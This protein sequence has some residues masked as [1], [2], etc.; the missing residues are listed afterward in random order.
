MWVLLLGCFDG[1]ITKEVTPPPPP[2]YC[3]PFEQRGG[4][5]PRNLECV[6]SDVEPIV[7]A[8]RLK[9]ELRWQGFGGAFPKRDV[10]TTPLVANLTDDNADGIINEKDSP[11]IV[12]VSYDAPS[13]YDG[14]LVVLDGT[15]GDVHFTREG[16]H[17]TAGLAIADLNDDGQ[18]DI[19]GFSNAR[20]P[21]AIGGDGYY[22]WRA[23]D[24]VNAWNPQLTIADTDGEAGPEVLAG[25]T[26]L[27][28]QNGDFIRAFPPPSDSPN[29]APEVADLDRDGEAEII[30]GNVVFNHD[31]KV[32]WRSDLKNDAG[33]WTAVVNA[34]DD[35]DGE[36]LIIGGGRMVLVEPDGT[37]ITDIETDTL[38]PGPPCIADFDGDGE[39]EAGWSD[40]G[41]L[42]VYE[43]NG[44]PLW[45]IEVAYQGL[46][47]PACSAYDFDANGTYEILYAD[48]ETLMVRSGINGA[49][50]MA[51][52]HENF[53]NW[54]DYPVVADVDNDGSAEIIVAASAEENMSYGGL[55]VYGHPADRWLDAGDAW[56]NH[57]FTSADALPDTTAPSGLPYPWL[58]TNTVRGRPA[59]DSA[60]TDLE[61][62]VIDTCWVGCSGNDLV[63]I[64]VQ[65]HNHGPAWT[66][67]PVRL[68]VYGYRYS[69]FESLADHII[70]PPLMG[71]TSTDTINLSV[72]VSEFLP[73]GLTIIIDDEGEDEALGAQM[74]C[75]ETNN[76]LRYDT[77]PCTEED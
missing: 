21:S 26:L 52:E 50:R 33:L 22:L 43:L 25:T 24:P 64:T 5:I 36:V 51:V 23:D 58:I 15:T 9:Q 27:S 18:P 49:L 55:T 67:R 70:Q 66:T 53:R 75:N 71:G 13:L 62:E 28:G 42:G 61:V 10:S 11:D 1:R 17:P 31:G 77:S 45:Q 57:R 7:D 44:D 47:R 60:G 34:D 4:T 30:I 29:F 35:R 2:P 37:V 63:Q 39:A 32:K 20:K 16:W 19:V 6:Q 59:V 76:R 48:S 69:D 73:N 3:E 12:F 8:W 72:K 14:W 54:W 40:S 65:V 74:E 56:L 46:A 41:L 38:R 68:N